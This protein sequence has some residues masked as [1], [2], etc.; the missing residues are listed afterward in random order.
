MRVLLCLKRGFNNRAAAIRR[1]QKR[2]PI[3]GRLGC[4]PTGHLGLGRVLVLVVIP[5]RRRKVNYV[6]KRN[7]EL[8]LDRPDSYQPVIC[9]R[10]HPVARCATGQPVC[11][12]F[13][14]LARHN[15]LGMGP[16]CKGKSA[17]GHGNIKIC[18]LPAFVPLAQSQ[19]NIHHRWIGPAADIG[20]QSKWIGRLVYRPRAQG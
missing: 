7:P 9:R 18:P 19:Q 6:A 5:Q 15:A 2:L 10:I 17:F 1:R 14:V 16:I 4:Q 20:N 12:I 3:G 8:F 11:T 13:N